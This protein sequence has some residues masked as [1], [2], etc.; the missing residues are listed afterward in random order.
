M[1]P[2]LSSQPRAPCPPARAGLQHA[3]AAVGRARQGWPT[4]RPAYTRAPAGEAIQDQ[5][6]TTTDQLLGVPS[7]NTRKDLATELANLQQRSGAAAGK[8]YWR[9]LE[10]LAN[11]PAFQ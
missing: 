6:L 8:H 4:A 9:S 2:G 3:L 7:M 5:G 10:E 11:T 1:V